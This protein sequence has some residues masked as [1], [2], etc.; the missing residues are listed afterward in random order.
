MSEWRDLQQRIMFLKVAPA[1]TGQAAT[2]GEVKVLRAER[3]RVS[4]LGSRASAGQ[5]RLGQPSTFAGQGIPSR[6]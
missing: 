6:G 4:V 5:M 2:E 3:G 1:T